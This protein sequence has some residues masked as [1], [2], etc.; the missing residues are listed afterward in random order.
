M[1]HALLHPILRR[2]IEVGALTVRYA[3]GAAVSYGD[4]TGTPVRVRLTNAGARHIAFRQGLGLGEAYMN[5]DLDFEAGD[6]WSLLEITSANL[7]R[8]PRRSPSRPTRAVHALQRQLRQWNDRRAAR[9]NVARHYDLPDDLYRGFLDADMQ[10]SCAYFASDDMTLDEAQA[11][12]I[13]HIAAKLDLRPGQR[14]LDVG[15]GW[16]GM[17]LN[18]AER[19]GAEV[20]GVTLSAEQLAVARRR[21]AD[22]GLA[23]QARFSLTDYRDLTG[24]YDRIVS[25]G[26]LEHVGAPN[27][28]AYFEQVARLLTDEGVAVVHAIGR[29]EPPGVTDPFIRKYIFPGGYIPAL[30]QVTAAIEE[31]G[32]WMTDIEILRRHYAETLRHWRLNFWSRRP[33]MAERHGERFCRMWEFYLA[34]SESAFRFG[35]LFVF[36]IQLSRRPDAL[37]ITRDYMLAAEA[38]GPLAAEKLRRA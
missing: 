20:T 3:D 9:R 10:Y 11:A 7:T 22:A 14:V 8:R 17:A 13:A 2:M 23:D 19:H 36:Q 37:P 25:V 35:R 18:L 38:A 31:A 4:G 27:F 21:A 28:R 30:S 24:P 1:A 12:K 32:L 26:M 15:C 5:G 16:G 33:E 29:M 34:G 6:V